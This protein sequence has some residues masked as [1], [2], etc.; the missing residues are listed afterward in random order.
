MSFSVFIATPILAFQRE[1]YKKFREKLKVLA[2][3]ISE[4]VTVVSAA[5]TVSD[6]LAHNTPALS[7]TQ[8]FNDIE[9]ATHFILIY[10]RAVP[11]GALVE[12]GYALALKKKIL[13][14]ATDRELLPHMA[15]ELD[16]VFFDVQISRLSPDWE[17]VEHTISNFLNI[18]LK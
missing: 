7:A 1:E 2:G 15:K 11:T 9:N 3:K 14:L 10:P 16:D 13:I 12:L 8:D 18:E 4:H 17:N 6:F 5:L